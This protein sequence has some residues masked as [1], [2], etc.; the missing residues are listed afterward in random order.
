MMVQWFPIFEI[1]TS[2][3]MGNDRSTESQHNV[4]RHHILQCLNLPLNLKQPP[5]LNS[6]TRYNASTVY[7]QVLNKSDKTLGNYIF[8]PSRAANSL[9]SGWIRLKF[10]LIKAF[11]HVRVTYKNEKDQIKNES[12]RVATTFLSL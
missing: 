4:W 10:K 6:N 12:A 3:P 1:K 7:L 8:R 9:V 2:S 5:G 11:M